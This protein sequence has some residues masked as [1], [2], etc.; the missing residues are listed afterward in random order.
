MSISKAQRRIIQHGLGVILFGLIGGFFLGWNVIGKIT[1]PPFPIEIDYAIPGTTAAWRAVHTGSIM[2]GIMA[3][4]LA[5]LF[6]WCD[7]SKT[8]AERISWTI[9]TV[10]WGNSIFYLAAVFAPNH[11]LSWGSNAAG[12]GNIAGI[13]AYIPAI[14]AAYALIYVIYILMVNVKKATE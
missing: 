10:I 5:A 8:L 7:L 14:I 1:F 3:L 9:I 11:G 13:I 6:S 4:V 12:E 2:N